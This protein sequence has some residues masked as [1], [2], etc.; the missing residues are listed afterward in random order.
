M[1]P[2]ELKPSRPLGREG[3]YSLVPKST[4]PDSPRQNRPDFMQ[5]RLNTFPLPHGHRSF[6][7]SFSSS[8]LS[9]WTMRTPRFTFVSEGKPRR[10]LRMGMK[11]AFVVVVV[12]QHGAPSFLELGLEE[13]QGVDVVG[14]V[15]GWL[16]SAVTL[17]PG[18][19]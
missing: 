10:R 14:S 15:S 13:G 7:P 16:D 12:V 11:G 17:S 8:S 18:P 2:I 19:L 1:Q 6:L 5:H 4:H 9:P 3:Q